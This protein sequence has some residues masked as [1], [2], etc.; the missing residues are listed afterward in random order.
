[1]TSTASTPSSTELSGPGGHLDQGQLAI[2]A[3]AREDEGGEGEA[4][5]A[6]VCLMTSRRNRLVLALLLPSPDIFTSQEL[7]RNGTV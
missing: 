4:E 6:Y 3:L 7:L 1:M 5:A 2:R